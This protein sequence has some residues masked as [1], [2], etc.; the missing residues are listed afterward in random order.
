VF[1]GFYD[2]RWTENRHPVIRL[3][4]KYLRAYGFDVGDAIEVSV[5]TGQITIRKKNKPP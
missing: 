2:N 3:R 5:D 1:Y 4:G